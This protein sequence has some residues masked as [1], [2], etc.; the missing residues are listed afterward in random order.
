MTKDELIA[1][2]AEGVFENLDENGE[3]DGY[4]IGYYADEDE[5]HITDGTDV[6]EEPWENLRVG[7]DV[8]DTMGGG[9]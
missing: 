7:Q 3:P 4:I 5:F 6:W 9:G 2:L 1:A 8:T